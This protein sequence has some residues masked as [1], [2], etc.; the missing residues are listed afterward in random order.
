MTHTRP[1]RPAE[2]RTLGPKRLGGAT[3]CVGLQDDGT[4]S[5]VVGVWSPDTHRYTFIQ[6]P[7]GRWQGTVD[8][9]LGRWLAASAYEC[10]LDPECHMGAY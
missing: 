6:L 3:L 8:Y 2:R 10:T 9:S 5:A 1:P 7:Q 4:A